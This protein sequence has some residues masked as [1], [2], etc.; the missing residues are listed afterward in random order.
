MTISKAEYLTLLTRLQK[1]QIR[2]PKEPVEREST[3]HE[4]IMKHCD[5]Q[6]PKWK[7]LRARMDKR[8]TIASG[9]QDFTIFAPGRVILCECKRKGEKPTAEQLAWHKELELL[10]HKV[11]VVYSFEEFL[12]AIK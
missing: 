5:S 3:L 1:N 8:S 9:A 11:H 6:W 4:Q 2:E 7:Y 12:E 10:G